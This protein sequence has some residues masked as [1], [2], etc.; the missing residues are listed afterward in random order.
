MF[1]AALCRLC[2]FMQ[3]CDGE[4][5][6]CRRF[7]RFW[8]ALPFFDFL[9]GNSQALETRKLIPPLRLRMERRA[10][11]EG[12]FWEAREVVRCVQTWFAQS[13]SAGAHEERRVLDDSNCTHIGRF[14]QG[15]ARAIGCDPF[16]VGSV[17]SGL[18]FGG[19]AALNHRLMAVNPSGSEW[20]AREAGHV[21]WNGA[22]WLIEL[23]HDNQPLV[24]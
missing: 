7:A 14:G 6:S 9:K 15:A 2:I 4:R 10:S 18:G 8:E 21:N 24:S 1:D 19:V 3:V 16:G 22:N 17:A 20:H 23:E 11:L 5:L 13:R 12:S